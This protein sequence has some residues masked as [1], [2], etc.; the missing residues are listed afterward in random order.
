MLTNPKHTHTPTKK[1]KANLVTP[2]KGTFIEKAMRPSVIVP[3]CNKK[4]TLL[5][6]ESSQR[7]FELVLVDEAGV[8]PVVV[9]EDVL[10][11]CDVL[12]HAAELA[13]VHPA[14]V[15]PVKHG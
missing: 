10:P 2:E 11:V 3:E 7:L 6:T 15:F 8:V 12:P 1:T 14:F 5:R 13:E 9:P 4:H